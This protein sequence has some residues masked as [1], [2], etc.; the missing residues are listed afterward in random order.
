MNNIDDDCDGVVDNTVVE[1]NAVPDLLYQTPILTR[2]SDKTFLLEII[3]NKSVVGISS[4]RHEAT[5]VP[6][7]G[8]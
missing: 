8:T 4:N 7:L 1:S 2:P 5:V 6:S 3:C